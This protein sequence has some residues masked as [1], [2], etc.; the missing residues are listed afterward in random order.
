VKVESFFYLGVT[1]FFVVIGTIYWFTSYEDAGTTMLAASSLLGLLA[2]GYLLFQARK[3]PPRP[4]DRP[5][6]TLAEGAGPVDT[7]P[8]STVWPFVFGFGATVL[9]TGFIFGIW[10]V[11]GGA[12]VLTFGIIGMI[13]QS[14]DTTPTE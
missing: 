12:I 7:F 2:G 5:D 3:F 4:E 9:A 10:V 11:L 1:A 6:A 8:A 14:R 13:R